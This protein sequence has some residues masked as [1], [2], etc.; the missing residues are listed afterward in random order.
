M[1][2]R[3]QRG[4]CLVLLLFAFARVPVEAQELEP[5]PCEAVV[6]IGQ[7]A[8]GESFEGP[9]G[10]GLLFR[11]DA[12]E[13]PRNPQGWTVRVSPVTEPDHDYSMVVTPP[14]R[15]SNPRYVDTSYGTAAEAALS[16]TPRSFAFV[17]TE[18]DY[19]VASDAIAVLLWSGNYSDGEIM[20]AAEALESVLTFEGRLWIED[21]ET[22]PSETDQGLGTIEWI[23]FRAEL[24]G[25][26]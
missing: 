3:R 13:S 17:A 21:G 6:I 8:R 25:P 9:F 24:C 22:T 7:V 23:R 20:R 2:R 16:N 5:L 15:F 11:M 26:E 19:R 10:T 4:G 12:E 1:V 14:Y 18:E